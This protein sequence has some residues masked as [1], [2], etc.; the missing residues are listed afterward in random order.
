MGFRFK[1][2][3]SIL[4]AT[5]IYGF[6]YV[7]IL[8]LIIFSFNKSRLNAVWTG[9]TF[10]WYGK[11]MQNSDVLAAAKN[12]LT[13]AAVSTIVAT[14]VGT[15][16]AVGMYR[17]HFRGKTALDGMLYLPIVIPEIVMGISLLAFFALANIPLGIMTLVIAHI[18][19]CIPFVVVIVR[20]RL[21]GFDRSLEEAARDLG[22]NEWQTFTKVTLPI[23]GPGILAGA[24]LSFT[25]S[26]DDVIISFFV[27]GPSSTTLPL[28]IFS[29]VKFG[30]SPEINALSTLMLLITLTIAVFA[31]L[32]LNK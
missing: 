17:Y 21:E 30:V 27:A 6:L 14:M 20:A 1:S 2:L 11:L 24:L 19:F 16:A 23:I 26:I 3:P 28:K 9:F 15:V 18:T 13:V 32:R 12:S 31:Q 7:P 25:L 22:A 5:F 8:V 4:Y 29:M 10:E